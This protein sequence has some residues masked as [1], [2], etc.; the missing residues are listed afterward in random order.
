MSEK[1]GKKDLQHNAI[2]MN[3]KYLHI[4]KRPHI[5][6]EIHPYKGT[7]NT[8]ERG[9]EGS[10]NRNEHKGEKINKMNYDVL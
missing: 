6:Q 3:Q 2:L 1:E 5:L 4:Q 10:R 8:L 9:E 7:L